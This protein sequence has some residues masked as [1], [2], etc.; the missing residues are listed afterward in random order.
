MKTEHDSTQNPRSGSTL[1]T[2]VIMM[3][4]ASFALGSFMMSSMTYGKIARRSYEQQKAFFFAEAGLRAA[5]MELQRAED[6]AISVNDSRTYFANAAARYADEDW[7]FETSAGGGLPSPVTSV[8]RD[9]QDRSTVGMQAGVVAG[10]TIHALYEH[11][12]YA[13]NSSGD[14]NYVLE[15]GGTGSGADYVLG[16]TY[17]GNDLELTGSAK[18]RN[19]EA[20]VDANGNGLRDTGESFNDVHV[21]FSSTNTWPVEFLAPASTN[22]YNAY[23]GDG[24]FQKAYNNGIF[25]QGEIFVDTI[26]NGVYDTTESFTDLDG[27][28]QWSYGDPYTDAN[29]NGVYDAGDSFTDIGNGQWDSGEE[30]EDQN[31][32]G[33]WDDAVPGVYVDPIPGVWHEG[34][35]GGGHYDPEPVP[36]YWTE[37]SPAEP[38]EDLGNGVY[39]AGEVFVDGNGVYDVGEAYVDDRNGVYDY[40]TQATGLISG[41]PAASTGLVQA[42]GGDVPITPPDLSNMHY[43][44]SHASAAPSGAHYGW[45]HDIDVAAAPFNGSGNVND[46]NNPAHIFRKNPT[47]RTY[48]KISGKHDYFLE[49]PKDST[50][51]SS[52][53]I[54]NP[55]GSPSS[56]TMRYLNVKPNGNNKVYYVDGNV[57]IHHP[58][59]HM[60]MFRN[61]GIKMTIVANGNITFS[62]EFYYNS[63]QSS[64]ANANQLRQG[65]KSNPM[66]TVAFIAIKDPGVSDSGN[67]YLGD[68]Q[69]G[70]GGDIHAFLYAE[71]DFVD[72]NLDTSGQ[73]FLSIFG[74]MSAGNHVLLNRGGGTG[75]RTRLDITLDERI[76]D[77]NQVPPGLPPAL[78]SERGIIVSSQWGIVKGSW[79]SHLPF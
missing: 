9:N 31:A 36:G 48:S 58:A 72:N 44:V 1:V 34:R 54:S 27:D 55:G 56:L 25:D 32:N 57:Y 60:F 62:D 51:S 69:F 68:Q 42:V 76:R 12:L 67:I 21:P 6:G 41:M 75:A 11:A 63:G 18:L 23:V 40:G 26:G 70:T 74:N 66:D 4:I 8:G 24:N 65:G 47:D 78:F 7:G 39:D 37:S 59:C 20:F 50:W 28:G 15:V 52:I 53:S 38:F 14:T 29:N 33:Q 46:I 13:G 64:G 17:S 79:T 73:P 2:V 16:D 71:N 22:A 3:A 45:G 61:A 5:M 49:D 10:Q 19:P 35:W 43:N 30:F 77:R